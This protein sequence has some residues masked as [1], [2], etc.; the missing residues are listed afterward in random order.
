[1]AIRD[2]GFTDK[3]ISTITQRYQEP[4][5]H[6]YLKR[7]E[8]ILGRHESGLKTLM[9][10]IGFSPS[11]VVSMI[12]NAGNKL[13]TT[14][15]EFT[16]HTTMSALKKLQREVDFS[17]KNLS[18]IVSTAGAHTANSIKTLAKN[19]SIST[20]KSFQDEFG[21][22]TETLSSFMGS[23]G[24]RVNES[25]ASLDSSENRQAMHKLLDIG[26]SSKNISSLITGSGGMDENLDTL[27][28]KRDKLE[29]MVGNYPPEKISS[30]ITK[31]TGKLSNKIDRIYDD[32]LSEMAGQFSPIEANVS[33]TSTGVEKSDSKNR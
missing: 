9:D 14:L 24:R 16:D 23:S 31:S 32:L 15:R 3:H 5:R 10:E 20:L 28:D 22:K 25:I 17:A 18:G 33:A 27:L 13:D 1:M 4:S 30:K 29:A 12:A 11:N 8:L 21:M 2:L 26:L 6:I 7:T 19:E